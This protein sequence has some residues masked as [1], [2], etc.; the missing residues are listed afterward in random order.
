MVIFINK[1][2]WTFGIIVS[3]ANIFVINQKVNMQMEEEIEKRDLVSEKTYMNGFYGFLTLIFIL[4]L[5][6]QSKRVCISI[7]FLQ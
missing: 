7:T 2:Y 1:D 4:R 6:R 3:L 5:K